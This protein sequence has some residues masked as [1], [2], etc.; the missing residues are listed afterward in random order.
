[1]SIEAPLANVFACGT[2]DWELRFPWG[3]ALTAPDAFNFMERVGAAW[4][5][6]DLDVLRPLLHPAGSWAFVDDRPRV[7][8][9]PDEL[10]EAIRELQ[11]DPLYQVSNVRHT[12]L[13]DRIVLG[14]C[15]VRTAMR[16]SRGHTVAQYFLL[17]EVRDGLFYRSE[18]FPSEV[19]ARAAVDAGWASEVAAPAS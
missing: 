2:E 13:T 7:I 16:N 5:G 9:D 17:L 12:P 4:A 18:S 15:Q 8:T 10:V 3:T 11:Q 1:M 6:R 19:A 14:S